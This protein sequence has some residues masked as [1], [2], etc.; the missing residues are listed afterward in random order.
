MAI[1][2]VHLQLIPYSPEHLLALFEGDATFEERFGWP[3]ADGL[4]AFIVSDEVSPDWLA[5]LR[6]SK[7]T[8]AWV[9]GFAVVHQES[10]SVIGTVGFKGPPDEHGMVEV[11]YGVVPVFEGRGYAT[12]AAEA[13]VAFAF[14]SGQV[15]LV[16]AHTLP[17]L[18]ASTR[19]ANVVWVASGEGNA[20]GFWFETRL[21][22]LNL[23]LEDCPINT[24]HLAVALSSLTADPDAVDILPRCEVD[25]AVGEAALHGETDTVRVDQHQVGPFAHGDASGHITETQAPCT[26]RRGKIERILGLILLHKLYPCRLQIMIPECSPYVLEIVLRQYE[27]DVDADSGGHTR[28]SRPRVH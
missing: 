4:R 23:R 10:R 25:H 3:A 8:D 6:A 15:R 5:R 20:G 14:G 18:N 28:G 24:N 27:V 22:R 12:E 1:E 9:H 26:Q 17:T 11:A 2:T 7:T 19:R 16:R 13:A 21:R